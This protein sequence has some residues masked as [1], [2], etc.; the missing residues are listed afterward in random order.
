MIPRDRR[1]AALLLITQLA[2]CVQS[3]RP[4]TLLARGEIAP[5]VHGRLV[6]TTPQ[7]EVARGPAF[8]GLPEYVACVEPAAT[9]AREARSHGRRGRVFSI[10]GA[11]LGMAAFSGFG[12]VAD[13]DHAYAYLGGALGTG[14][15]GLGFAIAGYRAKRIAYGRAMDAANEYNDAVGSLGA[16][17]LDLQFAPPSGPMP[18]PPPPNLQL[19]PPAMATPR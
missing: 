16:T 14:L 17:C 7:G 12:A 6:L 10:V 15:A 8:A 3:Y 1:L 19:T 9:H 13:R 5:I 18:P 2:G 4:P 11:V